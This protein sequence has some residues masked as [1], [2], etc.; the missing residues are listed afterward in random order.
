MN[1]I[2]SFTIDHNKLL[3]GIYVSRIDT[4]PMGDTI[5]TFDIRMTAPNREPALMP[6][7]LHTVEHLAATWLRNNPQ[8]KDKIIYWGPMGCCTGNYLILAGQFTPM[9]IAPIML[10]L[11]SWISTFDG[12]IPGATDTDCGNY[13]FNDLP[14]AK[15]AARKFLNE[16]L[17]NLSGTNTAYPI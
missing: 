2:P 12:D 16:T 14:G 6:Q 7:V 17:L 3:P 9:D 10:E 4:T 1:K 5:T 11:F 13:T 15:L 8:W